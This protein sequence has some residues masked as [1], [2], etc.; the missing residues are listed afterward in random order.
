MDRE[1][2]QAMEL[3]ASDN[4]HSPLLLLL[5]LSHR[6]GRPISPVLVGTQGKPQSRTPA[7]ALRPGLGWAVGH[8]FFGVR[9]P[10]QH[11]IS[12][13][14]PRQQQPHNGHTGVALPSALL[15]LLRGEASLTG[16]Q[17][18]ELCPQPDDSFVHWACSTACALS[19]VEGYVICHLGDRGTPLPRGPGGPRGIHTTSSCR[20]PP[21]LSALAAGGPS[22]HSGDQAIPDHDALT[23]ERIHV[24]QS[25]RGL[26]FTDAHNW[27]TG[28]LWLIAL[29]SWAGPRGWL[30]HATC[31]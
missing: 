20:W 15:L 2:G 7:S 24:S 18:S 30:L 21:P 1:G 27:V 25:H 31:C 22:L 23:T 26:P 4:V 28:Q 9:L 29:C 10:S 5:A 19:R 8:A 6:V 16:M 17:V 13:N 14:Q 3:N 11:L 12:A